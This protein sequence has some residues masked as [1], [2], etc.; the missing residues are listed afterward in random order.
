MIR[1]LDDW[2][3]RCT[4]PAATEVFKNS[5]HLVLATRAVF[6]TKFNSLFYALLATDMI[7]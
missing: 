6:D 1:L 3:I 4:A 2:V 5:G 7:Y